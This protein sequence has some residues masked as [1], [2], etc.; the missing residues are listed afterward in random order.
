MFLF[1]NQHRYKTK[2]KQWGFKCFDNRHL[3]F[4]PSATAIS[5]FLTAIS[6]FSTAISAFHNKCKK[7]HDFCNCRFGVF[8]CHVGVFDRHFGV[9]DRHFELLNRRFVSNSRFVVRVFGRPAFRPPFK[10][11]GFLAVESAFGYSRA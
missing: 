2:K 11:F 4:S 3:G 8:D 6:A 10:L 5:A 9:F 1:K 7:T